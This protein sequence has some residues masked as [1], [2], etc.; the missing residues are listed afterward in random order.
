MPRKPR[1][2]THGAYDHVTVRGSGRRQVFEGDGD[3]EHFLE[4]LHRVSAEEG[5]AIFAW[6]LMD[7]HI[8]LLLKG[9]TK[10]ISRMMQRLL[11][12]YAHWFNGRHGHVGHVFQGRYDSMP[13]MTD[14]HLLSAI[15]YIH[16]NP[17]D[18]GIEDPSSYPWSSYRAYLLHPEG[19][20]YHEIVDVFG[21][22]EAFR[23]FHE[24]ENEQVGFMLSSRR[25]LSDAEADM[26]AKRVCGQHYRDMLPEGSA[27]E[28]GR[29]IAELRLAGL[30]I[31]Q[32]ERLTGIGRGVIAK[33]GP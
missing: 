26:I 25:R 3:R 11:T 33:A 1:T 7:N 22:H 23:A 14:E 19:E 10:G 30:S 12:S 15:K 13:I 18:M 20:S 31:R 6:C 27:A 5:C 9:E 24:D 21:G 4:L 29:Q 16:M 2:E 17:R 32:I 8:H 28:R